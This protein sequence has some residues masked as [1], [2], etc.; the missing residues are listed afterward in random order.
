M[1]RNKFG[2]PQP[3]N[4]T[5]MI[6]ALDERNA[7]ASD[8]WAS[9]DIGD[10]GGWYATVQ[11]SDDGEHIFETVEY[12]GAKTELLKDLKTAGIEVI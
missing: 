12:P 8:V 7:D 1:Q 2:D 9:V 3:A 6:E 4:F 11:H 10:D 5:E